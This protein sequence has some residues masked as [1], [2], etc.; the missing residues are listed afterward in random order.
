MAFDYSISMVRGLSCFILRGRRAKRQNRARPN[1]IS[2]EG[3]LAKPLT[4]SRFLVR[5]CALRAVT[6]LAVF[7]VLDLS[8]EERRAETS[9][10]HRLSACVLIFP[11]LKLVILTQRGR[12]YAERWISRVL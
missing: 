1:A 3:S 8:L 11:L 10:Y 4:V 2:E 7:G 12:T 9:L 6:I 5:R